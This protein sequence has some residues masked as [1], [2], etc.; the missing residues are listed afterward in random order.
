MSAP[1]FAC[2]VYMYTYM[3]CCSN[4]GFSVEK[5]RQ[6]FH[7][8]FVYQNKQYFVRKTL[9]LLG[10]IQNTAEDMFISNQSLYFYSDVNIGYLQLKLSNRVSA[11]NTVGLHQITMIITPDSHTY[12]SFYKVH[13]FYIQF[14]YCGL[15]IVRGGSM[16]VDFVGY[17]FPQIYVP[18]HV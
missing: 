9:H 4:L 13:S 16:F 15:I 2:L 11:Q 3:Y 5:N 14:E 1:P 8:L 6:H 17:T 7:I 12:G 10:N 18:T